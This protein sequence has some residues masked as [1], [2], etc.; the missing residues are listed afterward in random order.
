[1]KVLSAIVSVKL[2]R[3]RSA[4]PRQPDAKQQ[5]LVSILYNV[6]CEL[7]CSGRDLD[8]DHVALN[9]FAMATTSDCSKVEQLTR[10][11]LALTMANKTL[12]EQLQLLTAT[13]AQLA[14]P[15]QASTG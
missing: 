1:M 6:M 15:T 3:P 10:A 14:N 2:Q 13:N 8:A 11:N 7:H 12:T 4:Q 9:N 5:G